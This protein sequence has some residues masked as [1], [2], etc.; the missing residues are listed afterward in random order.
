MLAM[1][2]LIRS[3]N[4]GSY[5]L[6]ADELRDLTR[7]VRLVQSEADHVVPLT[8]RAVCV[9]LEDPGPR[10]LKKLTRR[11]GH[12]PEPRHSC[13]VAFF[14]QGRGWYG[15]V[16]EPPAAGLEE[17]VAEV[18][19]DSHVVGRSPGATGPVRL[20]VPTAAVP[21]PHA[22]ADRLAVRELEV[23]A[24]YEVGGCRRP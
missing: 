24:I 9:D 2:L 5:V 23:R 16:L 12:P 10:L 20:C 22:L 14:P 7:A 6:Q 13:D 11:L 8:R 4:A 1:L 15:F 17:A 19:P 21:D 3:V 18:G